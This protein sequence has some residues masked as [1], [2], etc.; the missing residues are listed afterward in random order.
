VAPSDFALLKGGLLLLGVITG[1]WKHQEMLSSPQHQA[2][3][4]V[5]IAHR[6]G[7]MYAFSSLVLWQLAVDG[8]LPAGLAWYAVLG[9]V[10]F[11]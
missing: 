8:P 6:A 3:V 7:P 1:T 5:D 2:P 9:L 4:Y 11:F 10:A